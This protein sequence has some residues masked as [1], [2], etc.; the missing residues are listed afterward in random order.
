MKEMEDCFVM[1]LIIV[2]D[3]ITQAIWELSQA[4]TILGGLLYAAC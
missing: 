4:I 2:R 1:S 3:I